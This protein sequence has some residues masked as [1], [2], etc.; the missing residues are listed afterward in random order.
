[1]RATARDCPCPWSLRSFDN[2]QKVVKAIRPRAFVCD[3]VTE[4]SD[5]GNRKG[6]PLQI[7]TD[8]GTIPCGCPL[9]LNN[10][11]ASK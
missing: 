11:R 1:M 4:M 2:F 8:V 6:L 10:L 7:I 5:E 3:N 9:S